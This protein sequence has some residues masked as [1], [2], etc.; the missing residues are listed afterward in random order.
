[1]SSESDI[2]LQRLAEFLDRRGLDGVLLTRRENFAWITCGRDNHIPNNSPQ[3]V[4]SILATRDGQRIC[5]ANTIEAPRMDLEELAGMGV[6]TVSFPWYN[7]QAARSTFESVIAG[8]KIASDS[9]LFDLT[10]EPLP[11]DFDE[12]RHNLTEAEIERYRLGG[13]R[14]ADAVERACRA[15]RQGISEHEAAGLLDYEIHKAGLNPLV[16]LVASD[17]RILNF[18][19]PIPTDRTVRDHVMLVTC[20]EW[21]GLISCLTRFVRF[22]PPSREMKQK[23]QATC[24]VDASVNFA[25]LPGRT[26]GQVFDDLRAAYADNGYPDQWQFH[27][28]GG[29]TGYNT[30]ET[31]ARPDHPAKVQPNQA[32]AWNP[33]I[34]G[35]KSEDTVLVKS[36]GSIEVLTAH[37]QDWPSIEGRTRDGKALRRADVLVV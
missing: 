35:T 37:S 14:A 22:S 21:R 5:L 8:R 16:T 15:I 17:D 32:F 19:H 30:R 13:R 11:A 28:Q 27:H 9:A 25:T 33:S 26:L 23:Q 20:A 12:L 36:D 34:T 10:L 7:P 2:K 6:Q 4:A 3:G 18:R 29:S 24:N 1:M 31:V